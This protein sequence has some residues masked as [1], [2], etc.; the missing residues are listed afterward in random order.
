MKTTL[1]VFAMMLCIATLGLATSCSKDSDNGFSSSIVGEWKCTSVW[2]ETY[3]YHSN[4][5]VEED[6]H[7]GSGVGNIIE[8]TK[9]GHAVSN[10]QSANY[11][12]NGDV[13]IFS[14]PNGEETA[15]WTINELTSEKLSVVSV[16]DDRDSDGVGLYHK[17]TLTFIKI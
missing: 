16:F 10:G 12:I 3:E 2:V 1:K 6:S 14:L 5:D 9:D 8:F 13:I 11:S 7:S 17:T 15:R 4:G